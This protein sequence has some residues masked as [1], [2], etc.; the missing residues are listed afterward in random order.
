MISA[1]IYVRNKQYGLKT[2]KTGKE[3]NRDMNREEIMQ[4][5]LELGQMIAQDREVMRVQQLDRAYAENE[6]LQTLMT[7]YNVR[8]YFSLFA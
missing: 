6:E 2:N 5:A 8:T 7:E 3:T 1:F 4:K